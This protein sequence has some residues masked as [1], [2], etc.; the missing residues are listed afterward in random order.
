MTLNESLLIRLY[1]YF[2]NLDYYFSYPTRFSRAQFFP[3]KTA[4]LE[5][6]TNL[7]SKIRKLSIHKMKTVNSHISTGNLHL[8][9]TFPLSL[10]YPKI[11]N[12]QIGRIF[13]FFLLKIITFKVL[14]NIIV[15]SFFGDQSYLIS[16]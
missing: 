15:A 12:P 8:H 2:F 14:S 7:D 1:T 10:S 11:Q 6:K 4:L 16:F 9:F 13:E 5:S 3:S